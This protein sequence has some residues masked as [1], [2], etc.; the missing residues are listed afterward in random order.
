MKIGVTGGIGSGKTTVCRIIEAMGY[1]VFYSDVEA[2]RIMNE[3]AGV[4][5]KIKAVFGEQAYE[6]NT[7][8]TAYLAQQIFENSSL[9]NTINA[10][11]HPV[12]RASFEQFYRASE[13]ELVFNEAAILFE[14]GAYQQFDATILVTASEETRIA[15]VVK[16]D[17]TDEKA[18]KSRMKA[19][20]P[21]TEKIK[22]ASYCIE[23]E[24]DSRLLEQVENVIQHIHLK[25]V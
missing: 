22:L 19:Q 5:A 2:K 12:V 17:H 15:R 4:V 9:R 23:N 14:T 7:L 10:I 13:K 1:P 20:M 25:R 6:K 11:V 16:R 24:N 3:D 18:V 21:D 8:N